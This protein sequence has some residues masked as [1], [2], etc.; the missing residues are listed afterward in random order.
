VPLIEPRLL[1]PPAWEHVDITGDVEHVLPTLNDSQLPWVNAAPHSDSVD[2][3][4]FASFIAFDRRN[5]KVWIIRG[6]LAG[7]DTGSIGVR[8][9]TLEAYNPTGELAEIQSSDMRQRLGEIR[10]AAVGRLRQ[11]AELA[12][13]P[14]YADAWWR[15]SAIEVG[16]RAVS[17]TTS[18]GRPALP[19]EHYEHVARLYLELYGQGVKRGILEEIAR[20]MSTPGHPVPRET[21]RDW[22]KR[23]RDLEFLSRGRQGRAGAM[24][25]PR[26]SPN[27][28]EENDG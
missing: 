4:V 13:H 11:Q 9:L 6:L 22:V 21:A 1:E 10:D 3:R 8:Q 19:D 26:L 25:G 5:G 27:P 28:K 16:E 24:P 20:R 12:T 23:S 14:A 15:T 7:D 18:R 2:G 17:G